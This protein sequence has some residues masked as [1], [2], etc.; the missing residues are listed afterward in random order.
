MD[1]GSFPRCTRTLQSMLAGSRVVAG[2]Q[3]ISMNTRGT[4]AIALTLCQVW[5]RPLTLVSHPQV[6]LR[7]LKGLDGEDRAQGL[8]QDTLL[9]CK[10]VTEQGYPSP[11]V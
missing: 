1:P 9:G 3:A 8:S 5:V 4:M 7:S 2:I 6:P 11:L 10:E